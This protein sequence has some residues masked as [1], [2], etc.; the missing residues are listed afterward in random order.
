MKED[1]L[2]KS[3]N[4]AINGGSAGFMAMTGQVFGLMW[5]RTMINHQY[6][7]GG[8]ISTTFKKLYKEGG[9]P[10]FYRG[11]G[12]AL[13]Q[14]PISRFGDTAMNIGM[15]ELL[16]SKGKVICLWASPETLLQR[17]ETDQTRPLLQVTDPLLQLQKL[18]SQRESRYREA[19]H[20][21][22]TDELTVNEVVQAIT[23]AL[24]GDC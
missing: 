9:I 16:K 10:R 7:Y 18:I 2:T 24:Q 13:M 14:A 8:T 20:I 3:F 17:T 4:K 21:I 1:I 5:M 12:F 22:N 6:R 15:M 11:I 19:D 23:K